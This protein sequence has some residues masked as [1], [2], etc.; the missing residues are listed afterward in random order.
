M[1][2]FINYH[3]DKS[4]NK[5]NKNS[6]KNFKFLH[7]P[8]TGGTY[9]RSKLSWEFI[10]GHDFTIYKLL[11]LN[12][13]NY[14]PYST[15]RNPIDYYISVFSEHSIASLLHIKKT[16]PRTKVDNR[17]FE[18]LYNLI[19]EDDKNITQENIL[20]S[21][22]SL[23]NPAIVSSFSYIYGRSNKF[24]IYEYINLYDI[25]IYTFFFLNHFS[26][27]KIEN[28]NSLDK[29]EKEINLIKNNVKFIPLNN[30]DEELE[31][32]ARNNKI[33]LKKIFLDKNKNLEKKILLNSNQIE[34]IKFKERFL[35]N[36]FNF[37]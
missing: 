29:I 28:I 8:K 3:Y 33:Y 37:E 16:Q 36:T 20:E 13:L 6:I 5:I 25:G 31:T 27:K 34:K 7:I 32:I 22:L 21:L 1:K 35:F 11:K 30:I 4:I 15:V 18:F 19:T 14:Q 12:K 17:R 2:D 24:K 23:K 9:V 10:E 26:Q